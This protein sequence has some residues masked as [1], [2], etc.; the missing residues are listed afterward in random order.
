M[1]K[2]LVRTVP[3]IIAVLVLSAIGVHFCRADVFIP[4]EEL[5]LPDEDRALL[6]KMK[7]DC[8]TTVRPMIKFAGERD[9]NID[10]QTGQKLAELQRICDRVDS[11]IELY[12]EIGV[13]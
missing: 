2:F 10:I 3:F 5:S 11:T 7:H 1:N 8:D 4:Q 13:W 12:E 9:L 6:E